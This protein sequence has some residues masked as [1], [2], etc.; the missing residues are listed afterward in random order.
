MDYY[1]TCRAC[2]MDMVS[3]N[4]KTDR[5]DNEAGPSNDWSSDDQNCPK[6]SRIFHSEAQE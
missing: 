2:I 4:A 1:D 5:D 6:R 3:A